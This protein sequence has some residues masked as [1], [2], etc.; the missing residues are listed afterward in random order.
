MKLYSDLDISSNDLLAIKTLQLTPI[1]G[2][3]YESSDDTLLNTPVGTIYLDSDIH[4]D[5][6]DVDNVP[7]NLAKIGLKLKY[8]TPQYND[9]NPATIYDG[10]F[11]WLSILG[12]YLA[13]EGAATLLRYNLDGGRLLN[14]NTTPRFAS[15]L[16][17]KSYVDG[18][19]GGKF[20][21]DIVGDGTKTEFATPTAPADGAIMGHISTVTLYER[22][23]NGLNGSYLYTV[24]LADITIETSTI[25]T[26]VTNIVKVKFTVAPAINTHYELRGA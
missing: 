23:G 1:S 10:K 12:G 19:I 24:V 16:V 22:S 20:T 26:G 21:F 3:D 2:T 8:R 17:C 14:A 5:G 4:L 9:N 15:E 11:N 18:L 7:S 13:K 25:S 6:D